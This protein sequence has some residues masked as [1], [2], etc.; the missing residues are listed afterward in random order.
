MKQ[1]TRYILALAAMFL[2]TTGIMADNTATV[3][4]L[5]DGAAPTTDPGT[6]V[7]NNGKIT[8]QWKLSDG[9]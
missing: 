9:S 5:L 4:K 8:N 7:Y 1:T 6:V 2:F 3:T